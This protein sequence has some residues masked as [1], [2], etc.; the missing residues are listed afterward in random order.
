[1]RNLNSALYWFPKI[2]QVGL[3]VPKT[4]FVTYNHN[5]W[6][7]A[8]ESENDSYKSVI[9]KTMLEIEASAQEIG[10][11]VFFRTDQT[12]AKHSGVEAYL[13]KNKNDILRVVSATV[14]DNELKLWMSPDQPQ[15]F[16]IREFINLDAP[17]IAFGGHPIAREWR[18]FTYNNEVLC[19]HFYWPESAI[20]FYTEEYHS[21]R[22]PDNW[23]QL[24]TDLNTPIPNL[25]QEA[26]STALSCDDHNFWSIDFAQDKSGQWWLIDMALGEK[27]WHPECQILE[28]LKRRL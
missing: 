11:P 19:K 2:E 25:D 22:E 10:Y 27:S 6:L 1:M 23:K 24:L 17:F 21:G 9:E 20:K 8:V 5:E 12:S 15:A 28:D 7:D 16:M 3:K 26:I 14:E 4:V 13:I 18:Y